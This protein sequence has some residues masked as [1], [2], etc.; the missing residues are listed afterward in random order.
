M[1][2]N[3]DER[4]IARLPAV[5]LWRRLRLPSQRVPLRDH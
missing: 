1:A 5:S 3:H 2:V 4:I